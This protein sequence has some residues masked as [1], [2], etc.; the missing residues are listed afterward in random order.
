MKRPRITL[1]NGRR[2]RLPSLPPSPRR[3]D[4]TAIR[5][6]PQKGAA[7]RAIPSPAAPLPTPAV[8]PAAPPSRSG[9]S[10]AGD[11]NRWRLDEQGLRQLAASVQE[12]T[13]LVQECGK[14]QK[15]LV[16]AGQS[17]MH[18]STAISRWSPTEF[19]RAR[20]RLIAACDIAHRQLSRMRRTNISATAIRDT[21]IVSQIRSCCRQCRKVNLKNKA[22]GRPFECLVDKRL[23]QTSQSAFR[24][25]LDE[26]GDIS[27]SL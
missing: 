26:K 11:I 16:R 24:Y 17:W 3:K 2:I 9:T 21:R 20:H 19:E 13:H 18:E 27:E 22:A 8:P 25:R 14:V 4:A 23:N 15:E 1:P 5:V 6:R 10:E 12:I 7:P